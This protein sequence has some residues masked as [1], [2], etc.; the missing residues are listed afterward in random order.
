MSRNLMPARY[1]VMFGSIFALIGC[2]TY[3]PKPLAPEQFAAAFDSRRLD[4]PELRRFI[5]QQLGHELNAWPPDSQPPGWTLPTLTLVAYYYHPAL[6]LARASWAEARAALITAGGRPNPTLGLTPGYN[7]SASS[8]VTPWI[9]GATLDL[10]I[11]TAGKR[12]H[13]ITHARQLA[14]VA[15]WNLVTTAWQVR[16]G[17]RDALLNFSDAMERE[18]LLGEQ[19][20]LQEQWVARLQQRAEA[21]AIPRTEVTPAR[22]AL[23]KLRLEAAE[24]HRLMGENTVRL[25]EAIGVPVAS[26]NQAKGIGLAWH[27][28]DATSLTADTARRNALTRRADIAAALADYE[29][30]QTALQLEIAKQYPDVHL[31]TG[32]QWDQG[33]SKWNLGLNLELPVFNRNQGPI[34][35]AQA[36]RASAAARVEVAQA[37]A[38]AEID[39][40]MAAHRAAHG[41]LGTVQQLAGEQQKQAA[42]VEAQAR[43]GALDA[44]DLLG[45]QIEIAQLRLVQWDA[46]VK[47]MQALGRL[48]DA[49]QTPLESEHNARAP[50]AFIETNPR[51]AKEKP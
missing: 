28:P 6:T 7:F 36:R 44:V 18:R 3:E 50:G 47:A 33:Q 26:L 23:E 43:A 35:E 27:F 15:R 51:I 39:V 24:L 29:A 34:A 5:E 19:F 16:A 20:R 8:G 11:E 41:R 21:G 17:V 10:P 49:L 45:A 12:G 2:A 42:A 46:G 14:E 40:A 25:A 1:V 4:S 9:P 48:E 13:R 30:A 32:Y 31:G 22:I 37:R 38:I